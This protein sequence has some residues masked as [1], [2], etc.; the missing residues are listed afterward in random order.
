MKTFGKVFIKKYYMILIVLFIL[1]VIHKIL[2]YV[3][4]P[5]YIILKNLI[6]QKEIDYVLY[7][8]ERKDYSKI[9]DI[10]MNNRNVE[11][12]LPEDCMLIDYSYIIEDSSIHTYHRDYTSSKNCNNLKYPSYRI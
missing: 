9:K 3:Y 10:F 6:E 1:V 8:W 7:L 2:K 4:K 12:R 5:G 11:R